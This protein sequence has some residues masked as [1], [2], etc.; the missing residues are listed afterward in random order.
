[1]IVSASTL[2]LRIT[3]STTLVAVA[4]ARLFKKAEQKQFFVIKAR[5]H[6]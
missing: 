2:I 3:Y 5:P 4:T 1:M 6:W